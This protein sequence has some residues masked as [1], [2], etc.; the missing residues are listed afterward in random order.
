VEPA[1]SAQDT[2]ADSH[3]R[4]WAPGTARVLT[5][6]ARAVTPE[7]QGEREEDG[8]VWKTAA[9]QACSSTQ[10]AAHIGMSTDA[11]VLWHGF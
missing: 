8:L 7:E 1:R 11:G 10:E 3:L 5:P 6:D 4:V 2:C 9:V